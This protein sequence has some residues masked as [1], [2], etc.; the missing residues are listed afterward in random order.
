LLIL[1]SFSPNGQLFFARIENDD[2]IPVYLAVRLSK[3]LNELCREF[4]DGR[5][6][7]LLMVGP[8]NQ[9]MVTH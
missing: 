1:L 6:P 8:V 4:V 3:V 7:F 2:L 5:S 9:G